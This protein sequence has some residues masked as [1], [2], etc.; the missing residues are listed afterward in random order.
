MV[1]NVHSSCRDTDILASLLAWSDWQQRRY[2]PVRLATAQ[3][4]AGQIGNSA[5]TCRR[6]K[7]PHPDVARG[8]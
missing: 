8:K 1:R 2:L 6:Y 4:P 3:V 7:R 5:G